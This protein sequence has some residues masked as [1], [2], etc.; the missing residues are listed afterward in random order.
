MVFFGIL[1]WWIFAVSPIL[2]MPYICWWNTISNHYNDDGLARLPSSDIFPGFPH[3]I[4]DFDDFNGSVEHLAWVYG[5]IIYQKTLQLTADTIIVDPVN[6]SWMALNARSAGE[7]SITLAIFIM[8]ANCSGIVGSQLFQQSDRPLYRTGW[9]V[10][11]ALASLALFSTI[12]ANIQY[13]FLN[14]R[15]RRNGAEQKYHY[16]WSFG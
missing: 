14:R 15:L 16:W 6:G 3:K 5:A 10:I 7:R 12:V 1:L 11:V 8:S 2:P 4:C 9:T 13:W